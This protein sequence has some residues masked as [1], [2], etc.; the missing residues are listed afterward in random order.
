MG[1][2]TEHGYRRHRVGK[3]ATERKEE[4]GKEKAEEG[5]CRQWGKPPPAAKVWGRTYNLSNGDT[6]GLA[7]PC[8]GD[9]PVH[10][11]TFSNILVSTH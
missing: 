6:W 10:C 5:S 11:W 1:P 9:Y 3:V 4:A 2:V 8:P 7:P